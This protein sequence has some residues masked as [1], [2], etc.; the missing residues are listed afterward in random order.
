MRKSN[1]RKTTLLSLIGLSTAQTSSWAEAFT[2][3]GPSSTENLLSASA[4]WGQAFTVDNTEVSTPA[5]S[6]PTSDGMSP[7]LVV[8]TAAGAYA[9]GV[10]T[11]PGPVV[12][13]SE[14]GDGTTSVITGIQS[15][16]SGTKSF[17][18]N[19]TTTMVGGNG[20]KSAS[21]TEVVE[22]TGAAAPVKGLKKMG[23]A[24]ALAGA[25][26]VMFV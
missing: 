25:A 22:A 17:E 26:G 21:T 6:L 2:V 3:D 24:G 13:T 19:A 23:F 9:T 12:V 11:A 4:S 14:I 20:S 16:V 8:D 5:S 7:S 10:E 15:V 1:L 18:M